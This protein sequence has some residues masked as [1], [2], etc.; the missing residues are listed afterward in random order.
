MDDDRNEELRDLL[1]RCEEGLDNPEAVL[2]EVDPHEAVANI[3]M[4]CAAE[5]IARMGVPYE[6]RFAAIDGMIGVAIS[7]LGRHAMLAAGESLYEALT[8]AYT[9]KCLAHGHFPADFGPGDYDVLIR[10]LAR[11]KEEWL[12][13]DVPEQ[14]ID[15]AA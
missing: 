10:A 6:E 13:G 4:T 8:N 11:N 9:A 1:E 15:D 12:D 14:P 5:A 3:L 2:E 7:G